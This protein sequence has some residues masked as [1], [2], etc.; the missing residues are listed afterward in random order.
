[1]SDITRRNFMK[2]TALALGAGVLGARA[3]SGQGAP[4]KPA[5]K[6]KHVARRIDYTKAKATPTICFGCTTQCGVLGWVFEGRVVRITGNPLDPN[7]RGKIC[8]KANGMIEGQYYPER[9][10]YPLRRLGKRG[11]HKWKRITWDEALDEI[12]ARMKKIK[13]SGRPDLMAVHTGRDKTQGVIQRFLYAF[14]SPQALNRR[15]ICSSNPRVSNMSYFGEPVDWDTGD[16]AAT[17]YVINFGS[18]P[19]EAHQGG[20]GAMQRI[21]QARVDRGAKLVTFE[22]RPSATASVSDEYFMVRAGTDGAIAMAMAHVIL[23]EKLHNEAF[24]KRWCNFPLDKLA[25]HLKPFTPEFAEKESGV[26]AKDIERIAIEWAKCAPACL[27]LIN[28]G[29]TKHYNGAHAGRAARLLDILV[30]NIGKPGGFTMT[31]RSNWKGE[32][33]QDGLPKF[34]MPEPAPTAPAPWLPGTPMFEELPQKVKDRVKGW[35]EDMQKKYFGE[36]YTPSEYPL[37]FSWQVMRVGQLV[38]PYLKEGRGRLE[39]YFSYVFNA[40]YN[41]PESQLA[42][43]V[44]ADEKLIPFHVAIDVVMSETSALADI[45]LPET[46]SLERWDFQVTNAYELVPFTGIRQ[47]L[48]K[49]LGEARSVLTIFRDLA[50]R[51]GGGMETYFNFEEDEQFYKEAMKNLPISWDELKR[52]G[53]YFDEMRSKDYELHERAVPEKEMEGATVDEKTGVISK[54]DKGKKKVL[55]IM[56]D[57]KAIRGFPSKSRKIEVM[58]DLFPKAA[59]WAGLPESD[60]CS[61]P[62]PTYFRVPSHEN[63]ADNELHLVTFKWNVHTQSRSNYFKYQVEI[64]HNNPVWMNPKTAAAMGLKEGDWIEVSVKRP[65]GNTYRGNEP[66]FVASFKNRVKLLAGMHPKV[67]AC[68]HHVGHWEQGVVATA[69]LS[70]EANGKEGHDPALTD[71]NLPDNIWWARSKGG[72]GNGVHINEVFPI[73]PTPLVGTQNWYDC[74]AVVRKV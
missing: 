25:E 64:V 66:G 67:I 41:Y 6:V 38:Y 61:S 58:Q 18:N 23:R 2:Y 69:K 9:I 46:T 21:Q 74:V 37:S 27:T 15:A 70:A 16:Y 26:P 55:G 30:G 71:R 4:N 51:V 22:V 20:M 44:L 24:W 49:P 50:R 5:R 36:L 52:R 32:W 35:P 17:K 42:R 33:G 3:A 63:M 11:E 45:V 28:R 53:I 59:K 47:P 1:M 39:L 62:L 8:A 12:A 43:E 13:D 56:A 54:D 40:G 19:M 60:P 73:D 57:G 14:G 7:N 34:G 10:L 29:I 48:T 68:S 72:P 31:S 65:K